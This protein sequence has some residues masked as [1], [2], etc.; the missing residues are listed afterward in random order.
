MKITKT[1]IKL[2]APVN[3]WMLDVC[4]LD[5]ETKKVVAPVNFRFRNR[6]KTFMIGYAYFMDAYTIC[7]R[8]LE[9]QNEYQLLT[10]FALDTKDF[11][12]I[13]YESFND[14][15]EMVLR[16]RF[17]HARTKILDEPQEW[18][19]LDDANL[20][21]SN[22]HKITKTMIRP[23]RASDVA[24]KEVPKVYPY[25]QEIVRLHCQRD[26]IEMLATHVMIAGEPEIKKL[27]E[28]E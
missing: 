5:I 12:R 2:E 27:L 8:I 28:G 9:S 26:V 25:N 22:I 19:N 18:P 16:G 13:Y 7:L 10:M 3:S 17:A 21:F 1:F 20:N 6:W 23:P 14:F 4:Y 15:D 11:N 24:S